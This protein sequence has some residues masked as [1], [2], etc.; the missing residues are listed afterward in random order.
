MATFFISRW[1]CLCWSRAP[2]HHITGGYRF[3]PSRYHYI[4][5][6]ECHRPQ[7]QTIAFF[8]LANNKQRIQRASKRVSERSTNDVLGEVIIIIIII[9]GSAPANAYSAAK[10]RQKQPNTDI[11]QLI[12]FNLFIRAIVRHDHNNNSS[13]NKKQNVLH[14]RNVH[15]P[16]RWK[17]ANRNVL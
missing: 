4:N 17:K 5:A 2:H 7:G 16:V 12:K 8:L 10:N 15:A 13:N 6:H 1:H 14:S 11:E 9:I 3:E